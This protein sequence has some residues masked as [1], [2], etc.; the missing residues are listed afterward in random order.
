VCETGYLLMKLG[1][2]SR[3]LQ[4]FILTRLELM[5][6]MSSSAGADKANQMP[7]RINLGEKTSLVSSCFF[8]SCVLF[9][10]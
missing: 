4:N 10:S 6:N 1:T 5:K 3:D 8:F 2:S 9:S 7:V